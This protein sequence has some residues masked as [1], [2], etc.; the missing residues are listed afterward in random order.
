MPVIDGLVREALGAP[1]V[2]VFLAAIG[3][4]IAAAGVPLARFTI[5]ARTL[6]PEIRG[7]TALWHQRDGASLVPR[8]HGVENEPTYL[9]SPVYWISG[10]ADRLRR[11]LESP[12]VSLDFPILAELKAG[13][14]TD[15]VAERM[16]FTDGT[17]NVIT[18]ATDRPGGFSDADLALLDA[19]VPY[20]ALVFET[21]LTHLVAETLLKTYLGA[22]AGARVLEGQV[23][24]GSG[25]TITAA[26]LFVDI[27]DF[28]VLSET[29]SGAAVIR[30]L[31]E[32]FESVI[33][34]VESY[35][36]EV[37]KLIGD[38]ILAIIPISRGGAR[39]ACLAAYAAARAAFANLA[40]VNRRR[41]ASGE[42]IVRIGITFHV[43]SVIY[44]NIGGAGRLDFTVIGPAVNLVS[45]LQTLCRRLGK[46]MVLS[47]VFARESGIPVVSLGRHTLR[48]VAQS[49]EVFALPVH[50][51]PYHETAPG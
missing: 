50:E 14:L 12:D 42:P 16:R 45:R 17:N 34:A 39:P 26:V 48:G 38:G 29:L 49:Q 35:G 15:Y 21:R 18:W 37:L 41:A 23:T 7:F 20:L 28:T 30:L 25:Q 33:G 6:H 8:Y 46:G 19:I 36:G 44:G 24:R 31:N 2:N 40:E 10:G 51:D 22:D 43:G 47:E 27:R 1:D 11:R 32:Y 5:H 13:G 3:E 4:R 9:N